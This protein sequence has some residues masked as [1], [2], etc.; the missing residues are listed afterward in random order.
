M[1]LKNHTSILET[2]MSI[3]LN[4]LMGGISRLCFLCIQN[5]IARTRVHKVSQKRCSKMQVLCIS[6]TKIS[7]SVVHGSV[8]WIRGSVALAYGS[9]SCFFRQWLTR[10]Q[11]KINLFST[12]FWLLLF[13]DTFT[14]VFKDKKSQKEVKKL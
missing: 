5:S 8:I 1:N 13:E 4:F 2:N 14:S 7:G 10:C 9:G 12:F 11:Q 3:I 6:S